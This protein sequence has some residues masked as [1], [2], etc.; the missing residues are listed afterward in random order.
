MLTGSLYI[1]TS[2]FLLLEI[3]LQTPSRLV[4]LPLLLFRLLSIV[5]ISLSPDLISSPNWVF[6]S[7]TDA[8]PPLIKK[9]LFHHVHGSSASSVKLCLIPC[10]LNKKCTQSC[11]G[12]NFLLVE[13]TGGKFAPL[14]KCRSSEQATSRSEVSSLTIV[15]MSDNVPVKS[16]LQHPAGQSPGHLN[17]W[18]I[19]VQNPPPQ[20]KSC[21]NAPS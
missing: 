16:K 11:P 3:L 12:H 2:V 4:Y 6:P 19:F 15:G 9:V 8:P 14:F 7:P 21:L 5:L 17:F 18:K 13:Q 20:A 1:F 10:L